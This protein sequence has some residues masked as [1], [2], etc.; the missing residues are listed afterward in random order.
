M[1]SERA[2]IH[3]P[4][5]QWKPS[6]EDRWA[7]TPSCGTIWNTFWTRGVCPGCQV[8]WPITQ[9]LACLQ[10]SPHEAWYHLKQPEGEASRDVVEDTRAA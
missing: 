2:D 1:S 4:K 3:C 9:C 7:C 8:K 10:Y 5:C 6:H